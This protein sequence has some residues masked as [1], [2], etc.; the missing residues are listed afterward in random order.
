MPGK[1]QVCVV[2][3]YLNACALEGARVGRAAGLKR[4]RRCTVAEVS[5]AEENSYASYCLSSSQ[6]IPCGR[7][8]LVTVYL[9]ISDGGGLC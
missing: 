8:Q 2:R 6:I 9:D 3:R 4:N 1:R 7:N 5:S